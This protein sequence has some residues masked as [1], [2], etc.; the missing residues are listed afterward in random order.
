MSIFQAADILLPKT[1][2]PEK[3]AVIA[4]DQFTSQPEYWQK[5]SRYVGDAPSALHLILPEAY[6]D[7]TDTGEIDAIND[8]MRKYLENGLFDCFPDSYIYVERMLNSGRIRRG[9]IGTVDLEQ[10]DYQP[11]SESLIRAT[12][13][14][15]Q[16]RIPPRLRI[17][18]DAVLELP[19]ILMLCD[20]AEDMILGSCE[21]M[22]DELPCVYDFDLMMD[23]GH[24]AGWLVQGVHK[25]EM[26]R[27]IRAYEENTE[28]RYLDLC[29]KAIAYNV[30]DGNH[31]LATAKAHYEQRKESGAGMDH[32]ARR[33]MVELGNLHD[34]SLV[35]EPI[36]RLLKTDAEKLLA[37]LEKENAHGT[38][39]V[40]WYS[41]KRSGK[42]MLKVSEEELPLAV[43][44]RQLDAWLDSHYGEID[45]IHGDAVLRELAEEEGRIGFLLPA[46]AKDHLFADILN[47]GTLPRKTFSMGHANEKRYYI[48]SRKI[49]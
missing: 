33:A 16:E 22:K 20:D 13:F 27:L 41:G 7:H 26:D 47:G 49:V 38:F 45:F 3:W 9:I 8:N 2:C 21:K 46:I 14:T 11:G 40:P 34:E 32:P 18:E 6:L 19:H 10:Y 25:D 37:Y 1:E 31:S 15:V 5:V 39:P 17:R 28:N 35:F 44:Q 42:L 43:L 30:G 23:G 48:E 24:I 4:C 36:N 29:G 12:E